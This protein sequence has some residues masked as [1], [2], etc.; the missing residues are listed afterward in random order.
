MTSLQDFALLAC[1]YDGT[2]ASGGVMEEST[3]AALR[4]ARRCGRKLALVTGRQLDDLRRVC[5][6][7]HLFQ[8]VVTENGAVL[9]RPE[10]GEVRTLA[11]RPP[12]QFLRSLRKR[13]VTPL[14]VGAV[15][16]AT[17]LAHLAS[18]RAAIEELELD[19]EVAL[20]KD[21]VMVLPSGVDK[22]FGLQHI[23]AELGIERAHSVGVGDAEN[24]QPLLEA[25]GFGVAVANALPAI[26]HCS[27]LI[28][29]GDHGRGIVE[30]V[31]RM[32]GP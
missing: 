26:K 13:G 14:S 27:Q 17:H 29:A 31:E 11:R 9:F 2:L 7:L 5:P 16:V 10:T 23:L 3:V 28:T 30:V 4:R 6:H 18:T 12:R 20:N 22:G 32:C 15:I 19:L 8:R 24:D 1:D 21:A 25:A